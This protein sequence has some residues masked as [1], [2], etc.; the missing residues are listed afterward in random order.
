[1]NANT[2]NPLVKTDT[3]PVTQSSQI[4]LS[5]N[6]A[7][8]EIQSMITIARQYPRDVNS[9]LEEIN[10]ACRSVTLAEQAVYEYVR[11]G[12]MI[13]GPSIRLAEAVSIAWGNMI[14]AVQEVEQG[15]DANGVGY[16][17]VIV[18]SWDL[19]KNIK[20]PYEFR[21]P[22]WRHTSNGGYPLTNQ[23]D[24][25]ELIASLAS[26]RL[27]NCIIATIPGWI[28]EQAV[29]QCDRTLVE[30]YDEDPPRRAAK[31][32]EAYESIGIPAGAVLQMLQ[33][34]QDAITPRELARLRR[35]YVSIVD[36]FAP[37]KQY[38]PDLSS[39]NTQDGK[40]SKLDELRSRRKKN[41]SGKGHEKSVDTGNI[42]PDEY[43]D[44]NGEVF[45][46]IS[47]I[48]KIIDAAQD[49]SSADE[50]GADQE[51]IDKLMTSAKNIARTLPKSEQKAQLA[52]IQEFHK[53][54]L[55]LTLSR[56]KAAAAAEHQQPADQQPGGE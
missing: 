37:I 11:G 25:F 15:K 24:I 41:G 51:K 1:M 5:S 34:G 23:R 50:T 19:Q 40:L 52:S 44:T 21:V 45:K 56:R 29:I 22:H 39:A 10:G 2:K 16:S 3:A 4:A 28:W 42:A 30:S 33:H 46:G 55:S 32:L 6:K 38:F 47:A 8:A 36:G 13:S 48:S 54:T 43:M 26:R 7:L 27:R 49:I 12:S 35:I 18:Y 31:M 20:K 17:D 14:T 53:E 9:A